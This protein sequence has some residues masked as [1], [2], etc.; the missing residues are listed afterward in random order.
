MRVASSTG[1]AARASA[2]IFGEREGQLL[3]AHVGDG[4][5]LEDAVAARLQV[6]ADDVGEVLAVRDV[7]LVEDDD[8]GPVVQAAVLLAAPPR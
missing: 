2:T 7:D 1:L 4:G 6:R 8:A 5:H 3:Q